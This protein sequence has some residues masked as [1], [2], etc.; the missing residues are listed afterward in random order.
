MNKRTF[1]PA[2]NATM[3]AEDATVRNLRDALTADQSAS[4]E[5]FRRETAQRQAGLGLDLPDELGLR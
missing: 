1:R 2:F 5:A 3:P 4:W